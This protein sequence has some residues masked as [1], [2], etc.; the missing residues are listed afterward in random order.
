MDNLIPLSSGD[1]RIDDNL[2]K[3]NKFG[4]EKHKKEQELR[5]KKTELKKITFFF[6]QLGI[7]LI[8]ALLGYAVY[9]LWTVSTIERKIIFISGM[10]FIVAIAAW[11]SRMVYKFVFYHLK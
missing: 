6:A 1:P 4:L 7:F 2:K 5:N 10:A 11:L 3:I 9:D 8:P